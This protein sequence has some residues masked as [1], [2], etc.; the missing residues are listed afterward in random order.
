MDHN[1]ASQNQSKPRDFSFLKF[2][3]AWVV[4]IT[5]AILLQAFVLKP[6]Q[7]YGQ[8]ME[9]TLQDGDYL[10]ISKLESTWYYL[11]DEPYLPERG[12]IVVMDPADSPRLIKRV[13]GLPGERVVVEN[14]ELRVFNQQHPEGFDPYAALEVPPTRVSGSIETEV[15]AEHIFVVG[16]NR[17]SSGSSDSRNR[18]GTVPTENVVGSLV[19]RLWPATNL[20][21][22]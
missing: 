9:P 4:A 22:F 11:Q 17:Q 21:T 13:I 6:F 5:A 2:V 7:V 12:D 8:S 19:L 20:E 14:G 15:P 16:D 18:L 1:P 3:I 10:I